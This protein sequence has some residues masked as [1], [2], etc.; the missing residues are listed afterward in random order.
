MTAVARAALALALAA[1]P[2]AAQAPG[3]PVHGGGFRTGVEAIATIGW[4]GASSVTGDATT[5]AGTFAYGWSRVGVGGTVGYLDG[6][7]STPVIGLQVGVRLVGDG[8]Q[9]PFELGAFGGIGTTW[10][11]SCATDVPPGS[12][13]SPGL[14]GSEDPWRMPLGVSLVVAITTPLVSLRPWLAPRAEILS[15]GT[16]FAG[17]AG[18][19]LRFAGG[20]GARVMWDKVD[21]QDQTLGVGLSYRF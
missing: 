10:G 11:V 2:V 21:G 14:C 8:V 6:D 7:V 19:D 3:L 17:S 15:A 4:A 20:F 5:S 9:T 12:D 16:E 18:V 1:A 13:F